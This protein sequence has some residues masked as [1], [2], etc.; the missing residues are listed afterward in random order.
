MCHSL[1]PISHI[2]Y[3][4]SAQNGDKEIHIPYHHSAQNADKEIRSDMQ[5]TPA[6]HAVGAGNA[7]KKNPIM[8]IRFIRGG[9]TGVAQNVDKEYPLLLIRNVNYRENNF[10]GWRRQAVGPSGGL[11]LCYQR[12]RLH[13]AA[14]LITILSFLGK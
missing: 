8:L 6:K 2:P 5:I 7:D 10:R 14:L 11:V 3:H 9:R 1:S 13:F 4:H 12:G